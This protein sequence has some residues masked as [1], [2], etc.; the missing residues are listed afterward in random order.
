MPGSKHKVHSCFETVHSCS[1]TL[2]GGVVVWRESV[3]FFPSF[4]FL[5]SLSAAGQPLAHTYA[6]D[7]FFVIGTRFGGVV[8]WK[9][10][11]MGAGPERGQM[12]R[13]VGVEVGRFGQNIWDAAKEVMGENGQREGGEREQEE[14]VRGGRGREERRRNSKQMPWQRTREKKKYSSIWIRTSLHRKHSAAWM[15]RC[16]TC[17]PCL[18]TEVTSS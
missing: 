2:F 9:E 14:E 17:K 4:F 11:V 16:C 3:S 15:L 18:M 13:W 10:I 6:Y 1:C 12:S 7:F 5:F 8:V